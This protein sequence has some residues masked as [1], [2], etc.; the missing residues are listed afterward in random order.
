M[1]AD[2]WAGSP[3]LTEEKLLPLPSVAADSLSVACSCTPPGDKK[4]VGWGV[5]HP[6]RAG[7]CNAE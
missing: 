4:S 5:S 3:F 6:H 2:V 1:E 7:M